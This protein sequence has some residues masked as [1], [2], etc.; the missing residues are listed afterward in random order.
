MIWWILLA[1]S[2]IVAAFMIWERLAYWYEEDERW[3]QQFQEKFPGHCY[4][5]SH[6]QFGIEPGFEKPNSL[7]FDHRCPEKLDRF[8]GTLHRRG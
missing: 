8:R 3:V 1:V 2:V 5:C 7:P 6:H 4:V